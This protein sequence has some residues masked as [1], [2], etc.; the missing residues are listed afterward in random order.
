MGSAGY[1]TSSVA[2]GDMDN[3]GDLD[4]V[5]GNYLQ[6]SLVHQNGGFQFNITT[7][8]SLASCIVGAAYSQTLLAAGGTSP[9]HWSITGGTVPPGLTLNSAGAITGTPS[10][11]GDFQMRIEVAD[12]AVP[13]QIAAKTLY[14]K[15]LLRGDADGDG[16][17]NMGDVVKVE[18]IILG[19]D[20]PTAGADANGDGE[21]NMGEVTRIERIV[22]GLD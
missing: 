2:L 1:H 22:L 6:Q 12:S 19:L 18:R 9:F 3:D 14:L 17:V 5:V 4:I 16:G 11:K 7:P 10:V 20:P 8:S 13:A 15:I 21:I